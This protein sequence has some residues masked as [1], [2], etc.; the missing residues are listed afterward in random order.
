MG[1]PSEQLLRRLL[2]LRRSECVLLTNL[3]C[4]A[5]LTFLFSARVLRHFPHVSTRSRVYLEAEM[6]LCVH[7]LCVSAIMHNLAVR[8]PVHHVVQPEGESTIEF[9]LHILT[10]RPEL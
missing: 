3:S 7:P 4:R 9:L 8:F 2:R 1:L 10:R 6:E 5:V